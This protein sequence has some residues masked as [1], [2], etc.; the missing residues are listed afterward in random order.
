MFSV[1]LTQL[2]EC[3]QEMTDYAKFL[4]ESLEN[5]KQCQSVLHSLSSMSGID[6]NIE[7]LAM[8]LEEEQRG[9]NQLAHTLEEISRYYK[10]CE[11]QIEEQ[12]EQGAITYQ[13][14]KVSFSNLDNINSLFN[15]LD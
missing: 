10:H 15:E 1:N 6:E 9:F 5:M 12:Y 4:S 2:S 13:K 3:T 8:Q 7:T 14:L 11:K